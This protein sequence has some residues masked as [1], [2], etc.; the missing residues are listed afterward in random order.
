MRD[1]LRLLFP[2]YRFPPFTDKSIGGLSTTLWDNTTWLAKLGHDVIV[3]VP[4]ERET[5]SLVRG[6]LVKG[7]RTGRTIMLGGEL[8]SECR[9]W[10]RDFDAVISVNNYGAPTLKKV[11]GQVNV[12]RQI[13]TLAADRAVSTYL[14]LKWNMSHYI[15]IVWEKARE[16]RFEKALKGA[17]TICVSRYLLS[18]VLEHGVEAEENTVFIPNGVDTELFNQKNSTKKYD[19]LFVGRFQY[20]KGLDI[21]L[22]AIKKLW[23]EGLKPTLG[24]AGGFTQRERDYVLR[25]A[26]PELSNNISFLGVVP[27]ELMPEVYNSSKLLVVP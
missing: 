4:A 12:V 6:V 3:L 15:K 25:A 5:D 21:L 2:W 14:P 20:S 8:D 23:S 9:R 27:H 1:R 24:I 18:K 16:E 10:L 13:H 22:K 26:G 19:I 17:P 7:S 11:L